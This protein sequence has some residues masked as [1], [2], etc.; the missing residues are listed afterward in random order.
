[1][2]YIIE[3]LVFLSIIAI[4]A[5]SYETDLDN[6]SSKYWEC[7]KDKD[8]CI[9]E[10]STYKIEYDIAE[11]EIKKLREALLKSDEIRKKLYN[12]TR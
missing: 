5:H 7:K 12:E 9:K 4:I 1:M 10:L 8:T 11:T 6:L 3:T 2:W